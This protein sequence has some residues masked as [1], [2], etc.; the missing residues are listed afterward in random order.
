ML[1]DA[2]RLQAGDASLLLEALAAVEGDGVVAAKGDVELVATA[3]A[4][5]ED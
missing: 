5:L 3:G 2:R 1:S 4:T